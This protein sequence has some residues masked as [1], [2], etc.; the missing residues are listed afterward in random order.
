MATIRERI[1]EKAFELLGKIPERLRYSELVRRILE[2]DASLKQNTGH[3]T[4]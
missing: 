2:L 3:G 1:T 4:D